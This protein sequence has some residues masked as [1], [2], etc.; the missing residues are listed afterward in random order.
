MLI[1]ALAFVAGRLLRDFVTG[2]LRG[3]GFDSILAAL[4]LSRAQAVVGGRSPSEV[5]G[6][7]VMIFVMIFAT[8]EAAEI[9]NFHSLAGLLTRFIEF[10]VQVVM[11]VIITGIGF[12]LANFTRRLI[13][14]GGSAAEEGGDGANLLLANLARCAII[15]FSVALGFQQM[16]I[17]KEIVLTAFALVLGAICL[18]LALSF[19]L[20]SRD[21]AQRTIEEWARRFR[22]EK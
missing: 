1:L 19:G 6:T 13:L 12:Y 2:L 4:G 9:L 8:M 15:V 21:L 3:F 11:A 18:A 16:G 7:A 17:G 22:S 5:G 14:A 20:G 10:L